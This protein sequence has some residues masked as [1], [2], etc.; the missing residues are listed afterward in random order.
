MQEIEEKRTLPNSFYEVSITLIPKPKTQQ[1]K[2]TADQYECSYKH[3][4]KSLANLIQQ[5]I[6]EETTSRP[7]Q[8]YP[9]NA[10]LADYSKIEQH[11]SQ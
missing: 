2:K 4:S 10:S 9:R 6:K 1:G 11:N 8:V 3:S 7:S 5:S